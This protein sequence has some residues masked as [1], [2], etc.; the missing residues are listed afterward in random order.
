MKVLVGT[1]KGLWTLTSD[2]RQT[3]SVG[4]PAMFGQ[5][6]QHAVVDPRDER[7]VLVAAKTGHLGP[8]VMRSDD[9][10]ATW[11]EATKPPAFAPGDRLERA[12]STVF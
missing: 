6:I 5:I 1:R 4:E 2:D 8:T 12:L 3:W 11:N 7:L 9:G 10:G